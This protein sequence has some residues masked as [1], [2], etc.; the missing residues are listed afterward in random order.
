MALSPLT[1]FFILSHILVNRISGS[2][3]DSEVF[4]KVPNLCT[5]NKLFFKTFFA[6]EPSF[7]VIL[8]ACTL[9]FSPTKYNYFICK[10]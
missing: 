9:I 7:S 2:L 3:P 10:N 6:Y 8:P 4:E 1:T 5:C